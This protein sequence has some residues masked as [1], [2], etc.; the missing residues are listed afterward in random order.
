MWFLSWNRTTYQ[1]NCITSGLDV[2]TYSKLPIID[3]YFLWSID[4]ESSSFINLQLVYIGV[5]TSL[6]SS[7]PNLFSISLI[8]LV[9]EIKIP[10]LLWRIWRSRKKDSS[11]SNEI[12]NSFCISFANFWLNLDVEVVVCTSF[13]WTLVHLLLLLRKVVPLNHFLLVLILVHFFHQL[14]HWCFRQLCST[15]DF[16]TCM[17]SLYLSNQ[18]ALICPHESQTFS[19][20]HLFFWCSICF[21]IL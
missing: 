12:S 18:Q 19:F 8:Y 7:I 13:S 10:W 9:W 6:Q 21:Q 14:L 17:L 20:C 15:L 5:V 16:N 11:L 2:V 3:M 1:T 4:F